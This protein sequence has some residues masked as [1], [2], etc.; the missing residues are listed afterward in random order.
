[1]HALPQALVAQAAAA[2]AAHA[3]RSSDAGSSGAGAARGP[4]PASV[5]GIVHGYVW[6]VVGFKASPSRNK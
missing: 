2:T 1:M 5:R 3:R 4:P 6:T